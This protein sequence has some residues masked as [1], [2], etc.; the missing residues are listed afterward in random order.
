[1]KL[2]NILFVV[3]NIE[4]SKTFY[5]DLFGLQIITDLGQNV[6]L[7]EGLVLQDKKLWEKYVEKNV[8]LGGNDAELYFEENDMDGFL[9]KL[10]NSD[11]EI[12]F[13]NPCIEHDWGQRVVR[14]YDPDMHVIEVGETLEYV[15]RRLL[16][17]GMT[18]EQVAKKTQ[19]PPSQVEKIVWKYS[20]FFR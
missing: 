1:M 20:S 14:I 3:D 15:A 13:V 19:L 8:N 11:F 5:R 16:R 7:T 6:I 12:E 18:V 4:K 17:A 2:K 10:E 9:E